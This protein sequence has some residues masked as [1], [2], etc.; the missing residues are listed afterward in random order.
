MLNTDFYKLLDTELTAIIDNNPAD[1]KLNEHRNIDQNKTYAFLIWF[2][3]FYG[4]TQ[5]YSKYITDGK[6][7]N[8]CDIILDID[9]VE[10]GKIYYLI[11]SKWN[12]EKNITGQ[13]DS[14]EF[15]STLEDFKLVLTGDKKE[16]KNESFNR[17]Y[18]KLKKHAEQ[19]GLVKFVFLALCQH[20]PEVNDNIEAFE[21]E[22]KSNIEILDINRIKRDYIDFHYKKIIPDNPLEHK[23]EPDDEIRLNIEQLD[24]K[25]NYLRIDRPFEAYIFLVKPKTIFDLFKKYKFRLFF[26]NVRNPLITSKVNENIEKTLKDEKPY[27]WYFNNGITALTSYVDETINP[28]AKSIKVTGLQ[29]INGAQ[30]VYSVYKSYQQA[31]PR[32]RK[33]MDKEVL[34]TLRLLKVNS[35][36]LSLKITRFTNSQNPMEERDFW[37]NDD[38]QIQLQ[39]ASFNTSYWYEK[40]RGEFRELPEGVQSVSN[41]EFALLHLTFNL[42]KPVEAYQA[43]HSKPKDYS[44]VSRKDDS[45]G[46]YETIFKDQPIYFEDIFSAFLFAKKVQPHI[47]K[48]LHIPFSNFLHTLTLSKT[49]LEK[50]YQW[51]F[52]SSKIQ[53][54]K[55]ILKQFNKNDTDLFIKIA[56]FTTKKTYSILDIDTK[57]I[58]TSNKKYQDFLTNPTKFEMV[59]EQFEEMEFTDEIGKDIENVEIPSP[60]KS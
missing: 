21:R 58:I 7:D 32:E 17:Q 56:T 37:A 28:T 38:I 51:K 59:K 54:N 55:Q 41:Q 30:T 13:I 53:V 19:N 23:Y 15:K 20:N 3:N 33:I 29:I 4:Q 10:K 60:Q 42:Q 35:Q 11:Q 18:T 2:L 47:I 6:G 40:R 8:S 49:L 31:S 26:K 14:T 12:S 46:L 43:L 44:F 50:Y 9:D 5:T 34:L 48:R 57:P 27:F 25:K 52:K 45:M 22:F 24:I 16:T 36:E 39:Q 1:K